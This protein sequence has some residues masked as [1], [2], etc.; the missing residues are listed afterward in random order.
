MKPDE[1]EGG[2]FCGH[3]PECCVEK[4]LFKAGDKR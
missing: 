2:G 3:H 4:R 1:E